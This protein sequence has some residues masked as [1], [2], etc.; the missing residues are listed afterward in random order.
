MMRFFCGFSAQEVKAGS[1]I[2]EAAAPATIIPIRVKASLRLIL[3]SVPISFNY[4]IIS[5]Q[6][7]LH[8]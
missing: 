8:S 2:D 6:L 7:L 4:F 1:P 5:F 3:L